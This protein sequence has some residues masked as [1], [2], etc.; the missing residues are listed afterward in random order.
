MLQ[1]LRDYPQLDTVILCLD[2]DPAGIEACGR[3]AEILVQSG[4]TQI[5]SLQPA[6]KDW[7]EDLKICMGRKQ[8]RRR[9]TLRLQ[10]AVYGYPC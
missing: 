10:S 8:L 4:H 9:S 6:F 7:N 1:M 2:H 5:Q 3:L